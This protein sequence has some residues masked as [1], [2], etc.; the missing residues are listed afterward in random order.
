MQKVNKNTIIERFQSDKSILKDF[1][2][3]R[4]GLFG[5]YIRNEQSDG[6]DIDLLVEFD[7]DKKTFRNLIALA[8]Y[9]ESIFGKQVEVVT[10][11][12]LSPYLAPY[13]KKEVH[14][15]QVTD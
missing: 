15:V 3:D 2:V 4:I 14:Y 5:S 6:S 10:P 8:E 1:G 13:I 9:A 7:K 11:E 12:S